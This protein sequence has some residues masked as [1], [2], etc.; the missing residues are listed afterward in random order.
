MMWKRI[1]LTATICFASSVFSRADESEAA[2]SSPSAAETPNAGEVLKKLE[3]L[4]DPLQQRV[5]G[6]CDQLT[7][8]RSAL[9]EAIAQRDAAHAQL[10]S[11]FRRMEIGALL[12]KSMCSSICIGNES[13]SKEDIAGAVTTLI[14]E[15]RETKQVH[16]VCQKTVAER[17]EI[18]LSV[19]TRVAK[20]QKAEREILGEISLLK[21]ELDLLGAQKDQ[22]IGPV[23]EGLVKSERLLSEISGLLQLT[24]SDSTTTAAK[25]AE[26]PV[27][28][29]EI[30]EHDAVDAEAEH[31]AVDVE[32]EHDAVD[33]ETEH[34]AVDAETEH[35]AVVQEVDMILNETH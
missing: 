13:Y 18:L 10:K 34:D 21:A 6:C 29:S 30:S 27:Q 22:N 26:E 23:S 1:L 35:D 11:S 3:K 32:T 25:P 17:K 31:N 20:W 14:L 8:A 16:D 4:R 28:E 2:S 7:A 12:L 24:A 33:A 15:F 5:S 19:D 9:Q